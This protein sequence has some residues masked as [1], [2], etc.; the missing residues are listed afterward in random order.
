ME[1]KNLAELYHSPLLEWGPIEARLAAGPARGGA[2]GRPCGGAGRAEAPPAVSGP[3]WAGPPPWFVS[4]TAPRAA[5]AV[6]RVGRGGPPRGRWPW[7][8]RRSPFPPAPT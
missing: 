6:G 1:A 8:R 2:G 4:R 3:P 5:P 7:C